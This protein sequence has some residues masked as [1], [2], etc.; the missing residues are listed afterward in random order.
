MLRIMQEETRR[1]RSCIEMLNFYGG[2]LDKSLEA[3]NQSDEPPAVM[4][5]R[6]FAFGR[7][8]MEMLIVVA[9]QEA[10][11]GVCA[12]SV[13]RPYY[14]LATRILWATREPGGW[15][16][17]QAHWANE[18]RKWA[19]SAVKMP[20]LAEHARGILKH[21]K[22]VLSRTDRHGVPWKPAPSIETT[23]KDIERRDLDDGIR[24]EPRGFATYEYTNIYRLLCRL[25]HAHA[26]AIAHTPES[27]RNH[28]VSAAVVA[29]FALL[30]ALAQVGEPTTEA[31]RQA[32]EI[33]GQKIVK[34]FK[35][36][37]DLGLG[38]TAT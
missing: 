23:L 11:Y 31:A 38:D 19:E 27:H 37:T 5:Q 9:G 28:A 17:L 35:G 13:C 3:G 36:E 4:I 12:P 15:Q 32:T 1:L 6:A 20:S 2:R 26:V 7:T 21:R 30:R 22:D 16:R 8:A 29:T 25:A 33:V 10:K 18:D 24:E 14:E 34:V